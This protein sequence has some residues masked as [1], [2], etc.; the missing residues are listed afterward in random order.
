MNEVRIIGGQCRGRRISF[1][2]IPGLR[3]T[4]DAV[5][6]TLFNWLMFSLKEARCLDAFAGSGA[7]GF[8]ALSRFAGW[9]TFIEQDK[10]VVEMLKKNLALF[11]FEEKAQI[12]QGS[13]LHYLGAAAAQP[14]DFIFLDPPFGD[15]LLPEALQRIH[16]GEW[17][18]EKGLVYFEAP[19][20]WDL[21]LALQGYYKVHRHKF[22]GD[23]QFGLLQF[24]RKPA[25]HSDFED[26]N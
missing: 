10:N 18:T 16:A 5:R 19:R 7:L 20:A 11:G 24:V 6:E 21:G 22:L 25:F 9:V 2:P 17:L 23:V 13:A 8:E 3:P 12:V 26:V 4:L 14:F 1:K 15:N